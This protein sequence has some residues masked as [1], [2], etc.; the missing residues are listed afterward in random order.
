MEYSIHQDKPLSKEVKR[1]AHE[2]IEYLQKEFSKIGKDPEAVH[3]IRKS[4]K[5][6]RAVLRLFR[7]QI[8]SNK[9]DRQ[10]RAFRE[11]GHYF[12]SVRDS[13]VSLMTWKQVVT[14]LPASTR[15]TLEPIH[16]ILFQ[17]FKNSLKTIQNPRELRKKM[18]ALNRSRTG[19]DSITVSISKSSDLELGFMRLFKKAR[20]AFLSARKSQ[21]T[22]RL[23]EWR[24]RSKDLLYA[25]S[26]IQEK[27]PK[28]AKTLRKPIEVLT[29]DLG[30]MLDLVVLNR[31]LHK[32]NFKKVMKPSLKE[33]FRSIESK[34]SKCRDQALKCGMKIF[35]SSRDFF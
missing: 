10:N 18:K 11:I 17:E 8:S 29:E 9:F 26:L 31:N 21:T 32:R 33:L 7:K 15:L 5:K 3:E 30:S 34:R 35:K 25:L 6:L 1:V 12:S 13:Q 27:Y 22:E 16:L 24:K 4:L 19:V 20:K 28:I 14:S 23:H 2:L